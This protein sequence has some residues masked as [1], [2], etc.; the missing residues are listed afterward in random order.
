[1]AW[2]NGGDGLDKPRDLIVEVIVGA[3]LGAKGGED[4]RVNCKEEGQAQG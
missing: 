4:R 3:I 2:E 1:M